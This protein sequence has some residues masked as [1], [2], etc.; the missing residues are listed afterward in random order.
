MTK[1]L[2]HAKVVLLEQYDVPVS[3]HHD[4]RGAYLAEWLTARRDGREPTVSEMAEAVGVSPAA[5][6]KARQRSPVF[7]RAELAVR[8]GKRFNDPSL[9]QEPEPEPEPEPRKSA[10]V[11]KWERTF[12]IIADLGPPPYRGTRFGRAHK[13]GAFDQARQAL[14]EIAAEAQR[15]GVALPGRPPAVREIPRVHIRRTDVPDWVR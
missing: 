7:A 14:V 9:G 4:R 2:E 11:E 5:I 8:A 12:A 6:R 10:L 15:R 3:L 13:E 1:P